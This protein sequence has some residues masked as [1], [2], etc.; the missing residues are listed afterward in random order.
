M[1]IENISE[2]AKSFVDPS[3]LICPF[4][5]D[6]LIWKESRYGG[7]YGC[8]SWARTRCRGSVGCHPGT[9]IPLGTPADAETKA[10]RIKAHD[11]FDNM[12]KTEGMS[13][14]AAYEWL[15]DAMGVDEAHIGWMNKSDLEKLIEILK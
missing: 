10:L 4:C 8:A 14:K 5:G 6:K 11:L 7:F 13:R 12:W 3:T 2:K 9:K 1:G 15:A